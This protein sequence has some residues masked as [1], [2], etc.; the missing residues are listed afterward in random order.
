M[1]GDI[2]LEAAEKLQSLVGSS[3]EFDLYRSKVAREEMLLYGSSFSL[4]YT[5]C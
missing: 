1:D 4:R 5:T 2:N 3:S